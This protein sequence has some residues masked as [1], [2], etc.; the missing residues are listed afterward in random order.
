MRQNVGTRWKSC[1]HPIDR[2]NRKVNKDKQT[3][4][5]QTNFMIYINYFRKVLEHFKFKY[6][7]SDSIFVDVDSII[8]TVTMS[9]DVERD[10][11]EFDPVD[12]NSLNEFVEKS[13]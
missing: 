9:F 12:E 1:K 4:I 7:H 11:F 10:V 3:S 13:T 2:L 5:A 8:C 6:N